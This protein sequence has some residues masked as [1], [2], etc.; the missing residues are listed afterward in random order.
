LRRFVA[1]GRS[2]GLPLVIRIVH[3]FASFPANAGS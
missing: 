1:Q 3:S 2:L